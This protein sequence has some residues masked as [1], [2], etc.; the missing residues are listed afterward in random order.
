MTT[1]TYSSELDWTGSTGGGYRTYGRAH[2]VG[3]GEAG[4]LTVS[5][6]P[7]FRG[8]AALPNPEQLLL[9]AASSCQLLSFLAVAALAKV[10]IVGYTDEAE[11][12][13]PADAV[14]MRITEI[15]LHVAVTGRGTDEWTVRELLETAHEQCCIANTLATPVRLVADVEIAETAEVAA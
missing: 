10:D 1:H 4:S 3:L 15:T 12:I 7:A 6:D 13:T 2:A 11:A 9:A 5:A 8:D 14:P